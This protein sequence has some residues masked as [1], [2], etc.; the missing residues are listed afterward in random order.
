M[1]QLESTHLFIL[2][3]F[4]A[5]VKSSLLICDHLFCFLLNSLI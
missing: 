3:L 2:I 4:Y 1:L 5:S